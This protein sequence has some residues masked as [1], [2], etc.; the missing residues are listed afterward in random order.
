MA[1]VLADLP[2]VVKRSSERN[3]KPIS[4]CGRPEERLTSLF[5]VEA[6]RHVDVFSTLFSSLL[7]KISVGELAAAVRARRQPPPSTVGRRRRSCAAVHS[8]RG[9]L[10]RDQR[11]TGSH[12][13]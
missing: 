11:V 8:P 10:A 7:S 3:R 13:P 4:G 1:A 5:A 12:M 9:R 2:T 6:T